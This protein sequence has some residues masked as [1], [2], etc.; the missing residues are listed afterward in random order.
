[1]G[2][3]YQRAGPCGA[4]VPLDNDTCARWSFVWNLERP[5]PRTD[6]QMWGRGYFIHSELIPGPEHRP[7]R[8][9]QNDYL[10]D[11]QIQKMVNF[12]GI[13]ILA[14]EDYSVQESMGVITPRQNEHLGTT[15]VGIIKSR[16][17]LLR[18]AA[19]LQE[20]KRAVCSGQRWHL[21]RSCGRHPVAARRGLGARCQGEGVHDPDLVTLA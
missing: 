2:R 12:T 17:R 15:D 6:L 19:D 11:R 8:N 21:L 18:G 14:D 7:V 5:I 16:R 13:T 10:I 1:M 4:F 20:G 9:Y 3:V